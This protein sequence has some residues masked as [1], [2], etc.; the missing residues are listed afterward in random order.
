MLGDTPEAWR[1]AGFA[2]HR[3]GEGEGGDG[4]AAVHF[5]G[6]LVV[7]LTGAGGGLREIVFDDRGTYCM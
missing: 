2:V 7:R 3:D 6:G 1:S 4:A 5:A